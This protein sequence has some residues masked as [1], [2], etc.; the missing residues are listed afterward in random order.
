MYLVSQL[1]NSQEGLGDVT[2]LEEMNHG[3]GWILRFQ[4]PDAR[5]W[6]PLSLSVSIPSILEDNISS[7]VSVQHHACLSGDMLLTMM[8][9]D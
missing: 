1:V 5:S 8:I 7:Q 9:M 4:M 2:L 6:S 3:G